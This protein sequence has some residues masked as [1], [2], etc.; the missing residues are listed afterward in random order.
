MA[1]QL[2]EG[3]HFLHSEARLTHTDL[4]PEN[5]LFLEDGFKAEFDESKIPEQVRRK[6]ELLGEDYANESQV[7]GDE[8]YLIPDCASVKIIDFGGATFRDAHHT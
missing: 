6:A 5:I 4:K 2:L 1:K 8:P 7:S 3:L